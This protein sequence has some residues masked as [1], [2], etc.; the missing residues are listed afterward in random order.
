MVLLMCQFDR[1]R[2]RFLMHGEEKLWRL[3]RVADEQLRGSLKNVLENAERF[4]KLFVIVG[5]ILIC[6]IGAF[7]LAIT[8][9]PLGTHNF[10][11][12]SMYYFYFCMQVLCAVHILVYGLSVLV[13]IFSGTIIT[14]IVQYKITNAAIRNLE[15]DVAQ[16]NYQQ[17]QRSLVDI[18]EHHLFLRR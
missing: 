11:W 17:L 10:Q 12:K 1:A 3:S 14:L 16:K 5:S 18:V 9:L 15:V 13:M 6:L 7:S 2:L 4:C 8:G